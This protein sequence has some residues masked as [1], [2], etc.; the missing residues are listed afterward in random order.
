MGLGR[1]YSF[2][3]RVV[4]GTA[5]MMTEKQLQVPPTLHRKLTVSG[6]ILLELEALLAQM[7]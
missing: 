1:K 3:L 6:E 7:W 5:L 2:M 4:S